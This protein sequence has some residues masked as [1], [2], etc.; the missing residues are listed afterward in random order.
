MIAGVGIDVIHSERDRVEMQNTLD[1]AVLAAADLRQERDP[2][3]VVRDYFQKA[4]LLEHLN[5]VTVNVDQFERRVSADAALD[6]QTQFMRMTGVDRLT[7]NARSTAVE[8]VPNV[9]ISLVLDISGSMGIN[10]RVSLMKTAAKE[11][12][13]K[14]LERNADTVS[15]ETNEH[16]TSVSVVPFSGQ[17][18][19]GSTMFEY[20]GG[21]RFGGVSDEHETNYFPEWQ[22]DISNIVFRFDTNGDSEIDYSVKIEGYPDNDVEMFNKDDLDTYYQYAIQY[23]Y[24]VNPSLEGTDQMVGATIKGGKEPTSYFSTQEEGMG[25]PTSDEGPTKFNNVDMTIQFNDFYNG[26]V[27]NNVSSCIEMT[28]EDFMSTGLPTGTD[29]QTPYFVNW[30]YDAVTQDWGW[31]PEDSMAIQYAQNNETLLHDFIDNL[32]LHDGTGTNY[33]MKYALALLDPSTQPAFAHL[34]DNG[35][36]PTENQNR[37]LS[38]DGE[39]S[40]KYIVLMTDG[41][42]ST[43]IRPAETLDVENSDIELTG[44]PAEDAVVDSSSQSNLEMFLY[45]CS[46]AKDT[47]V[48]IYTVALETSEIATSEVKNCASSPSHFFEVTGDEVIETFVSI[49]SFIQKLRLIE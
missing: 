9:E 37:P 10:D 21:V 38:W 24:E 32:R 34:A 49:A 3:S 6:T 27:P 44:R 46:L 1:R 22:Q 11:F 35:E 33:G 13:S 2:E 20:L 25:D 31:C 15:G 19:P 43:Q 36:V 14:V 28:D 7:S 26:I 18:N 5:S 12:T 8:R 47:G 39:E 29:E 30:D 17:T 4:G 16:L 48:T 41:R 45:Q 40:S 42:T 23:I